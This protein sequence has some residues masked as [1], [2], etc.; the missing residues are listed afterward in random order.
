MGD[1]MP[2]EQFDYIT[3]IQT[4]CLENTNMTKDEAGALHFDA[5]RWDT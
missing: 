2:K 1:C 5:G 4:H 3:K